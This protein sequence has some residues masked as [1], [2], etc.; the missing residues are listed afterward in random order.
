MNRL[1]AS[2]A[3]PAHV[4]RVSHVSPVLHTP[5]EP[6]LIAP[7]PRKPSPILL[8][9]LGVLCAIAGMNVA[10]AE[11]RAI[12]A[13]PAVLYDAPSEKG[14]KVFVAPRGMPVEVV[15]AY[16]EWTKVRDAGGDL[17]WVESKQLTPRRMLVVTAASVKLRASADD[18]APVVLS[19]DRGVLLELADP[20][21]SGWIKVRHRDGVSGFV[22]AT[23]VWGD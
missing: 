9:V 1:P 14:R 15:L 5:R 17:S 23:E 10:A 2:L 12:G 13:A 7:S 21:S 3:L 16:G 18:T 6:A 19:A 20:V 8:T 22:R 11:F 4:L